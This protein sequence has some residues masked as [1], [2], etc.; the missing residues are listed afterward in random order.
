MLEWYYQMKV[1]NGIFF[2]TALSEIPTP[3]QGPYIPNAFAV[4][5]RITVHF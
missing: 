2:Q 4:T 5:L 3:G 1:V